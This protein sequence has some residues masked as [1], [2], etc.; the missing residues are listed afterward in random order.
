MYANF[1]WID[2][3]VQDHVDELFRESHNDHLVDLATGPHR[4][5][6]AQVADWLFRIAEWVDGRQGRAIVRAR[7]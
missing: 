7:A 3:Y 1:G 6:R 2:T 4:P 5:V